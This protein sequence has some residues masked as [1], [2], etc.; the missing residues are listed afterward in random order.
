MSTEPDSNNKHQITVTVSAP[1][2]PDARKFRWSKHMTVAEATSEAAA[3][4]GYAGDVSLTRQGVKLDPTKQLVAAGVR[5]GDKLRLIDTGG[6]VS[7][8]A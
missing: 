5:D 1:R 8:W 3:A 2:S 6:G 4:F 7:R